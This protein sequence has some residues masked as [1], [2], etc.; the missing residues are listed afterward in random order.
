MITESFRG[1]S[2][3]KAE[4]IVEEG[5]FEDG[6]LKTVYFQGVGSESECLKRRVKNEWSKSQENQD[7]SQSLK[8]LKKKRERLKW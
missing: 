6:M 8:E 7:I 1:N 4:F 2:T 5:S 3:T